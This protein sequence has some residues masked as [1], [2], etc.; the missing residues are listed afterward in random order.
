MDEPDKKICITVQIIG[1]IGRIKT[2]VK[3]IFTV[4]ILLNSGEIQIEQSEI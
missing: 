2:L 1:A 3:V 4:V